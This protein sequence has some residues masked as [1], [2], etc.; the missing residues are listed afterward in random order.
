MKYVQASVLAQPRLGL[1]RSFLQKKHPQLSLV[2]S[3]DYHFILD[4]EGQ[5]SSS[6]FPSTVR[7]FPKVPEVLLAL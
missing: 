4:L 6:F 3:F 7:L 1:Q 2:P 5:D